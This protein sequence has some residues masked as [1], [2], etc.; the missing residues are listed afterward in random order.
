[1]EIKVYKEKELLESSDLKEYK[2]LVKELDGLKILG[3]DNLDEYNEVKKEVAALQTKI[4]KFAEAKIKPIK[5][6][7]DGAKKVVIDLEKAIVDEIKK[8]KKTNEDD[9]IEKGFILKNIT[10]KK[11]DC[12]ADCGSTNIIK[13]EVV[14]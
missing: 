4:N 14:K 2:G 3:F 7:F 1:M 12:C 11:V 13:K 10:I 5:Q 6:A 9:A 8:L